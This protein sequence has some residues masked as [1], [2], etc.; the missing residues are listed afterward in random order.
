MDD[1]YYRED[2]PIYCF[3]SFTGAMKYLR[4]AREFWTNFEGDISSTVH[5]ENEYRQ[6]T[7]W[8]IKEL[9]NDSL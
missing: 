4:D 1:L 3:W 9:W 5:F 8:E 2:T 7:P 6:P